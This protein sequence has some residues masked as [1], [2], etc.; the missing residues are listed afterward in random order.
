M[1]PIALRGALRSSRRRL[2][3]V[4]VLGGLGGSVALH[5]G[6]PTGMHGMSEPAVCLALLVGAGLVLAGAALATSG[7]RPPAAQPQARVTTPGASCRSIPARPGALYL[8][9]AVLRL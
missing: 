9:F 4:L 1:S 7:P 6:L 2:A 5:H 8:R 3:V